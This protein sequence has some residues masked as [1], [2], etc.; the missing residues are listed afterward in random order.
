MSPRDKNKGQD[1][2]QDREKNISLFQRLTGA[3]LG[4]QVTIAQCP[5][6]ATTTAIAPKL[7]QCLLTHQDWEAVLNAKRTRSDHPLEMALGLLPVL[8][9]YHEDPVYLSDRLTRL[10]LPPTQI[11]WIKELGDCLSACLNGLIQPHQFVDWLGGRSPELSEATQ[12][13]KIAY[14]RHLSWRDLQ[15]I[16]VK[17]TLVK[18]DLSQPT[19]QLLQLYGALVWSHGHLQHC[20]NLL[21]GTPCASIVQAWSLVLLGSLRGDRQIASVALDTA[22][23]KQIKQEILLFWSRWSGLPPENQLQLEELPIIAA[24]T[25]LKYRPSLNLISQRHL[26]RPSP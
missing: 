6:L 12:L 10:P 16:L 7:W 24:A 4:Y 9:F 25:S 3:W 26:S 2:E 13:I 19:H 22:T 18:G 17:Q 11:F 21:A 14:Q 20:Q 15:P 1:M 5:A 23:T 8:L